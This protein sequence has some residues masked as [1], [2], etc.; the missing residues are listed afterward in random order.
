MTISASGGGVKQSLSMTISASGGGV[1]Q[2]LSMTI[3]ASG[4]WGRG[5]TEFVNDNKC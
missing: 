2:S 4:L 3:S 5:E 1:K